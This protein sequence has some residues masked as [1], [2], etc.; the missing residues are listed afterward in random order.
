MKH[1]SLAL[2]PFCNKILL[3]TSTC[4]YPLTTRKKNIIVA[5]SGSDNWNRQTR[6]AWFYFANTRPCRCFF[7]ASRLKV[8]WVERSSVVI[9]VPITHP[10]ALTCQ[11]NATHVRPRRWQALSSNTPLNCRSR[12]RIRQKLCL[13]GWG[14][15]LLAILAQIVPTYT[16]VT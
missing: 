2:D 16:S 1:G 12:F 8:E 4:K 13:L 6:I 3:I 5:V 15:I 11:S 7:Q 9:V 14:A 10:C